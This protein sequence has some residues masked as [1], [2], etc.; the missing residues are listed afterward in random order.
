MR[1]V[2]K[3]SLKAGIRLP[4]FKAGAGS[5]SVFSSDDMNLYVRA[6]NAFCNLEIVN[7]AQ[8]K[9][10]LSDERAT[11]Q[12]GIDDYKTGG[13][14]SGGDLQMWHLKSVQDDYVTCRSWDGSSEGSVDTYL[15]KEWKIRTSL[16]GETVL[17][18]AHTYTYGTGPDSNNKYRTNSDGTNSEQELI[19]PPWSI[20]EVVFSV[21][22]STDVVD[23]GSN[24]VT[25]LMVGR[26]AEWG[27]VSPIA[28]TPATPS[29]AT[30]TTN[31]YTGGL[32]VADSSYIYVSVG[33]NSWK[34]VAIAS[35]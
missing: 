34:R 19:I 16:A 26:S 22:G 27:K 7:G 3:Q 8:N 35:W 4:L 9:F 29:S 1:T 33:A 21:S 32:I 17:G 6:L 12:L 25:L 13:G 20:D 5:P 15:A 24:P 10:E 11:L 30:D 28:V 2:S 31:G 18:I 14:G 23:G